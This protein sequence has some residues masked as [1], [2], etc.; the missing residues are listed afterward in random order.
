MHLIQPNTKYRI[1][2]V[3]I[4]VPAELAES[5][6]FTDGMNDMLNGCL[7]HTEQTGELFIADWRFCLP[8]PLSS[9]V[10]QFVTSSDAPKEGELFHDRTRKSKA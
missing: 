9:T 7:M 3:Q 5:G 6:A 8:S 1:V 4:A 2:T 10:P